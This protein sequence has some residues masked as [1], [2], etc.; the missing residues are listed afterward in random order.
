VI[1]GGSTPAGAPVP[2]T[3]TLPP[4]LAADPGLAPLIAQQRGLVDAQRENE[5]A[6]QELFARQ[7]RGEGD[8]RE[9]MRQ[10]Q[11]RMQTRDVLVK[12]LT[13]VEAEMRRTLAAR[14]PPPD[15]P[16]APALPPPAAPPVAGDVVF[17]CQTDARGGCFEV[18][19][20]SAERLRVYVSGQPGVVCTVNPSSY[21]SVPLP[22]GVYTAQAEREDGR[23]TPPATI[24]ITPAGK[25]W[26]PAF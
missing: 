10:Q 22:L 18:R 21:C 19:N 3:L 26:T 17:S 8:T 2:G 4:A 6:L 20:T 12:R 23:R 14:Q 5:R 24:E 15:A 9:V 1:G 13:D 7:G 16:S 25:R 11:Q